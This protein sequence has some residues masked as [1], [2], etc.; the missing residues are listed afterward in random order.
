MDQTHRE[1]EQH[2]HSDQMRDEPT[3]DMHMAGYVRREEMAL[4]LAQHG[5]RY[6]TRA[7]GWKVAAAIGTAIMFGVP[8][9]VNLFGGNIGSVQKQAD[10]NADQIATMAKESAELAAQMRAFIAKA[11]QQ[12]LQAAQTTRDVATVTNKV[13][14]FVGSADQRFRF[15]EK[16]VDDLSMKQRD[17]ASYVSE[18]RQNE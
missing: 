3:S 6:V 4:A 2:T 11:D 5:E 13:S 17:L 9:A 15:L 1:P 18:K 10:K 8:I 12:Q 14:E 16:Q 7:L